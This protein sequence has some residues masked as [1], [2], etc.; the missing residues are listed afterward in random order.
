MDPRH[1]VETASLP[2]QHGMIAV[3]YQYPCAGFSTGLIPL[4]LAA[5]T[6]LHFRCSWCHSIALETGFPMTL[7]LLKFGALGARETTL[8]TELRPQLRTLP[9]WEPAAGT[10]RST[11]GTH[12]RQTRQQTPPDAPTPAVPL[13]TGGARGRPRHQTCQSQRRIPC[14]WC[15]VSIG[16]S[17]SC[18]CSLVGQGPLPDPRDSKWNKGMLIILSWPFYG[19]CARRIP[20]KCA[21]VTIVSKSI[22]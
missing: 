8:K 20:I 19:R 14:P 15:R 2:W 16:I 10:N 3:R 1:D 18:L 5:A 4:T 17:S 12:S 6:M 22:H 7:L 21:L 9:R 13:L 11:S